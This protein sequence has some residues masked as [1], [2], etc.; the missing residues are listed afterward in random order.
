MAK[1]ELAV[2]LGED[3]VVLADART[4]TGAEPC[5][6]LANDD[7]PGLHGLAVEQLH[8]ETLGVRVATVAG[9][10]EAFLV[11]HLRALLL[12]CRFAGRCFLRGGFLRWSLRLRRR[13]RLFLLR[14][15]CARTGAD[16]LDLDLGE[17]RAMPR[18]APV[19]GTAPVLAD[20][21]LLA[22]RGADDLHRH[23]DAR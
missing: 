6:A 22:E 11:C 20:P 18:V 12:C 13:L 19:A 5:A 23:L 1:R 4:G 7:H 3:R 15:C 2:A 21:D 10:T 16:R 8:A 9:G 17:L 14:G